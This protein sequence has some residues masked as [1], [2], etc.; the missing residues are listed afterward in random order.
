LSEKYKAIR[1]EIASLLTQATLGRFR[2]SAHTR[3]Q[4]ERASREARLYLLRGDHQAAERYVLKLQQYV[5]EL[6]SQLAEAGQLIQASQQ[7][8]V[9]VGRDK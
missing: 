7:S 9:N 3:R 5:M 2:V 8:Q 4:L 1:I 6:R